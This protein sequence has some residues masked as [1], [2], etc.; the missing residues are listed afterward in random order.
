M[1]VLTFANQKTVSAQSIE[2]IQLNHH[3]VSPHI[4]RSE[5]DRRNQP[6]DVKNLPRC[7]R[8]L[9]H[10]KNCDCEVK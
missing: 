4:I 2:K 10:P 9:Q 7:L 3:C 1:N 6:I 5:K 8:C